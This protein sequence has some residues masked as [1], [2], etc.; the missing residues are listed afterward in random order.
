LG[1]EVP[2]AFGKNGWRG[3]W[4]GIVRNFDV[5]TEENMMTSNVMEISI[6]TAV[7]LQARSFAMGMPN[8]DLAEKV[9]LNTLAVYA[10]E[11]FLQLAGIET[12]WATSDSWQPSLATPIDVADLEI[13]GVGK[14]ECRPVLLDRAAP[15]E[16]PLTAVTDRLAYV[17]VGFGDRL[18]RAQLLGFVYEY[19]PDTLALSVRQFRKQSVESLPSYLRTIRQVLATV[20][21]SDTGLMMEVQEELTD[22]AL[23]VIV[24]GLEQIFLLEPNPDLQNRR[25]EVY[26]QGLKQRSEDRERELVVLSDEEES[27]KAEGELRSRS[28]GFDKSLALKV[29]AWFRQHRSS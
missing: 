24:A 23:N 1:A 6:P 29:A 7:Q 27:V 8:V 12:H 9:Y 2:E 4:L 5:I 19:P 26:L 20:E 21:D 22:R 10:V 13:V 17:A 18:D 25:V 11:S 14:V 15:V 16:I 3:F 28:V